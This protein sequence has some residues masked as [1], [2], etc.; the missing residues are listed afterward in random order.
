MLY[1]ATQITMVLEG[2]ACEG[3]PFVMLI[4]VG[5]ELEG[6]AGKD[7][8]YTELRKSPHYPPAQHRNIL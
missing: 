6:E 7:S 8:I 5:Y 3:R 4:W 2:A 1:S